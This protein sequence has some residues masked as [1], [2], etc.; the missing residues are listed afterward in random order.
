MESEEACGKATGRKEA[1]HVRAE[2][3]AKAGMLRAGLTEEALK[4]LGFPF[5]E[6][7]NHVTFL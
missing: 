7:T 5:P 1:G 3:T 2:L 4:C 6:L